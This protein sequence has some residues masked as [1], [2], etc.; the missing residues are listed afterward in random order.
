VDEPVATAGGSARSRVARAA[1]RGVLCLIALSVVT[2][3][4]QAL[5]F[6][7]LDTEPQVQVPPDF[8]YWEYVTQRRYEGPTV[9][10]LGTGF[11]LTARHVGMGEI[12]LSGGIYPPQTHSQHTLLN[13]DGK[14]ADAMIFELAERP[15]PPDWPPIPIAKRP[16]E[17]GEEVLL[18]GFGRG[19]A[20]VIETIGADG[21]TRF[22]F[23]WSDDKRKRWGTNRI[24]TV[25]RKMSQ[26]HFLTHSFTFDFDPP[27]SPRATRNEAQAA[28]GDSG[29]GVFVRRDGEWRLLGM[30]VSVSAHRDPTTENTDFSNTS[31][32]DQTFA[33]DLTEYREEILRWTRAAC[34]N[35]RDDDGD[36][37]ID[38]PQ[39]PGC[40]NAR[41]RNERGEGFSRNRLVGA[42]L[43]AGLGALF[44]A[45][46]L[47]SRRRA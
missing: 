13:P 18:I 8:P 23:T 46:V 34:S 26:D 9:I 20:K 12:F 27:S 11:A 42:A 3:E 35:E 22:G 44:L 36:D 24:S 29:G 10:Y 45:S 19:R 15:E 28:V 37:L 1:L 6:G 33:V 4:A 32:G 14:A 2:P 25:Q 21:R 47:I 39:D 17:P 16:P 30:M 41:D 38:Y 40:A 31:Y 5:V 7:S 43:A